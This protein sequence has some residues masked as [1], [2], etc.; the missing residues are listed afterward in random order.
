MCSLICHPLQAAP[1]NCRRREK[2]SKT[3]LLI[4]V[5]LGGSCLAVAQTAAGVKMTFSGHAVVN[6][7]ELA[8]QEQLH[9]SVSLHLATPV[10]EMRHTNLPVPPDAPI[11]F[12]T[13]GK[14]AA[15]ATSPGSASQSASAQSSSPTA[16]SPIPRFNFAGQLDNQR[17][18]PPSA[19]AAVSPTYLVETV[20]GT[21][22][23]Q[24][25]SGS[26]LYT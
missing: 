19:Q 6:V 15:A 23:V 3:Y 26:T 18:V 17:Y 21:F 2:T 14:N 11:I 4:G 9:P 24:N 22:L 1:K 5:L 25:R 16:F 20:N 10:P 7:Q 12:L 8:E 13:K